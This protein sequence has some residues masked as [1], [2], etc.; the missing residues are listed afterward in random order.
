LT[1]PEQDQPDH[2]GIFL[3]AIKEEARIIVCNENIAD[4]IFKLYFR[5]MITWGSE[6]A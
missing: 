2:K 1:T 3:Q 5:G 4:K 6:S